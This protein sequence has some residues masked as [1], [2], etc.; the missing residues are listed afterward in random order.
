MI[1]AKIQK[2]T[3][4]SKIKITFSIIP[5]SFIHPFILH[6]FKALIFTIILTG[7]LMVSSALAL[8]MSS[9]RDC[10]VCHIMWLDDFRTDKETLIE[11]KP[12]N[13]LMRDTQGVVSSEEICYSCHDG[14]IN[15]SRYI[16]WKYNRHT[17]FVKPS[18]DVAIPIDLPL[19]V[20]GEIYCGTCHSA[21]GKGA[22]PHGDPTGLTSVF[23]ETN[24]DSSLCELCHRNEAAYKYSNGHPLHTK[25][26]ELPDSMFQLG[27]RRGSSKNRVIC[28]TC[29]K[30]HGARGDNILIIDN[31]N[32]ELC[33]L[34]HENQKYLVDTKHDLRLTLPD[35]K[36]MKQQLLTTSG[37]CGACHIPHNS[38][39][40]KL[41]ARRIYRGNPATQMCL[42]CHGDETQ[43]KT[44]RIGEHSH[45]INVNPSEDNTIP[46]KL[47]LFSSLGEKIP[48]G[49][50]QCFSC[51]DVHRWDPLST[52]NKGGKDAEGDASNSFLRISN[53]N[54]ELC[55]KCHEDK[56]QLITSDHNLTVT[57]PSR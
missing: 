23:R 31:S 7:L 47:P 19:S 22:A 26:L 5:H 38:A 29:H 1:Y 46:G 13:I 51:H 50:V 3:L 2:Q 40:K 27:S 36:N 32:S 35:E 20:K 9:K 24:I 15:D 33:I 6:I 11:W 43:Y 28:Q 8:E 48:Q 42:S 55:I 57:G 54:S 4:L 17:T 52:E 56:R 14:Y 53:M 21:H 30:V 16:V 45:S 44:K 18:K 10:V 49:A 39:G 25:T 37:P 34:C 41:W 12:G